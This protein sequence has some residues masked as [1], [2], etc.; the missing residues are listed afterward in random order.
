MVARKR[1]RSPSP[2]PDLSPYLA[3]AKAAVAE[4]APPV[5]YHAFW[6][7]LRQRFA[8][9]PPDDGPLDHLLHAVLA[10]EGAAGGDA[11]AAAQSYVYVGACTPET[12]PTRS[13]RVG[14]PDGATRPEVRTM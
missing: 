3:A 2:A 6:A 9:A 12:P 10:P 1:P 4:M 7:D 13:V 14:M 11:A 8:R 5:P